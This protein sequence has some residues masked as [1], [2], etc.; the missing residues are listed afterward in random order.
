VPGQYL[1]VTEVKRM[2]KNLNMKISQQGVIIVNCRVEELLKQA[3]ER[4]KQNRRKII[5]PHDL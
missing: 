1:N 2:V 4:A 5:M 3:V